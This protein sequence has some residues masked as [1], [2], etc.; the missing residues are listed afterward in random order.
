MHAQEDNNAVHSEYHG[1]LVSVEGVPVEG[2]PV[3]AVPAEAV[4]VE[5]VP[6]WNLGYG[7]L[8]PGF[9]GALF[10]YESPFDTETLKR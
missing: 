1:P 7:S 3:E 5:A 8:A 4:P 2:V 9:S 6:V 10:Y